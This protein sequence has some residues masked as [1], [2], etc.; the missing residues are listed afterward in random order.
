MQCSLERYGSFARGG[1]D[2]AGGWWLVAGDRGVDDRR[3]LQE[4]DVVA[5]FIVEQ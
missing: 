4:P 2:G 1:C 5:T 3:Q